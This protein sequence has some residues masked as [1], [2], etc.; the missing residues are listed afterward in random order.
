[1]PEHALKSPDNFLA[2][3]FPASITHV[4]CPALFPALSHFFRSL[5]LR[6]AHAPDLGRESSRETFALDRLHLARVW[7]VHVWRDPTLLRQEPYSRCYPAR[8]PPYLSIYLS[9]CASISVLQNRWRLSFEKQME[10]CRCR[11]LQAPCPALPI[12][13]SSV[14][15]P[16][17]R[18]CATGQYHDRR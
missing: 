10:M 3:T 16:V 13:G 1:M 9:V 7:N 11:P 2:H 17:Y 18:A 8:Y 12:R 6:P 4:A 5:V 14:P 15:R